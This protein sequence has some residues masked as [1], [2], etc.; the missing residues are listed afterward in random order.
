MCAGGCRHDIVVP[1]FIIIG[2]VW[3]ALGNSGWDRG[4]EYDWSSLRTPCPHTRQLL[5]QRPV[6]PASCGPV[7]FCSELPLQSRRGTR[8]RAVRSGL[9]HPFSAHRAPSLA[10]LSALRMCSLANA[11]AAVQ[12]A[13]SSEQPACAY[14]RARHCCI[15][16]RLPVQ[17][18]TQLRLYPLMADD[19]SNSGT[20][21]A[22]A[23]LDV[24]R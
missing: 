3:I 5:S 19:V 22:R 14:E 23:V 8:P 20:V 9:L 21:Y 7:S 16:S 18:F 11:R 13:R 24:C 12:V 17:T 4:V 15:C 2:Y 1:H 6:C 10:S